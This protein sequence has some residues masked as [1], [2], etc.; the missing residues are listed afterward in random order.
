MTRA[1]ENLYMTWSSQRT[2]F[3]KTKFNVPSRF[4][5]EAGFKEQMSDFSAKRIVKNYNFNTSHF[6]QN[7]QEYEDNNEI[8]YEKVI[9]DGPY[10]IGTLVSHAVFGNGK[11]IDKSGS[12]DNLKLV[13]LFSNGQW[14][15]LLAK[16]ANLT[17]LK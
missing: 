5:L 8:S 13:V 15:K 16:F 6:Y 14:K 11:I 10:P 7:S 17:I 3:G 2:V 4:L 12:G 9:D 1:K